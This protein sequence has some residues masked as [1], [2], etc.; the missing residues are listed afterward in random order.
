M[1]KR[2]RQEKK[3]ETIKATDFKEKKMRNNDLVHWEGLKQKI[4]VSLIL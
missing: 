1:N 2:R 4:Q 3:K